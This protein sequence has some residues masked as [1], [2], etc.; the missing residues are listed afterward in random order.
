MDLEDIR[1]LKESLEQEKRLRLESEKARE[2]SEK[3]R[4]ESEN[5]LKNEKRL[6]GEAEESF[7]N[8]KKLRLEAESKLKMMRFSKFKSL[9][10]AQVYK[11]YIEWGNLV[12]GE[13]LGLP[14]IPYDKLLNAWNSVVSQIS[15]FKEGIDERS[16]VHPF[17][18]IILKTI[19]GEFYLSKIKF[20]HETRLQN[21]C[22]SPDFSF[23]S[24]HITEP[25]WQDCLSFIECKS[26]D[27]TYS[28]GGGQAVSYLM[29]LLLPE[30]LNFS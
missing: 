23:T 10:Y 25:A 13:K 1:R 5:E 21:P 26:T 19:I 11:S 6:R 16:D 24:S 30:N 4:E 17:V 7:Q 28:E 15:I 27:V 20:H 3:A 12:D 14:I 8:E 29:H 18:E 9:P 2:E 22:L